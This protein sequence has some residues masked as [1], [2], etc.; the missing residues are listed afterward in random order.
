MNYNKLIIMNQIG[1]LK[2]LTKS[3][4]QSLITFS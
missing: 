2:Y 3:K 4:T 1:L